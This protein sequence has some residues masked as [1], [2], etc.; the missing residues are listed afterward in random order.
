MAKLTPAMEEYGRQKAIEL[1]KLADA[2][3]DGKKQRGNIDTT[4]Y[5][6]MKC[7]KCGTEVL[8]HPKQVAQVEMRGI[9]CEYDG[10][11]FRRK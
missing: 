11:K 4:K 9:V 2:K 6:I 5:A 10:G 1:R 8:M 3:I 7:V